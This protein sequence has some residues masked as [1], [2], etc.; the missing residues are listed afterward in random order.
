MTMPGQMEQ[1]DVYTYLTLVDRTGLGGREFLYGGIPF[2]FKKGQSELVVPKFVA[3]WM[4]SKSKEFVWAVDTSETPTYECP[5]CEKPLKYTNLYALKNC[6]EDLPPIW[7]DFIADTSPIERDLHMM[8]GTDAPLY[9]TERVTYE[10]VAIPAGEM[11]DRLGRGDHI[12]TIA[13]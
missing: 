12:S 10:P 2:V 4:F 1:L 6:P 5:R 8:E 7:G 11:R 13:R 9:R 3:E